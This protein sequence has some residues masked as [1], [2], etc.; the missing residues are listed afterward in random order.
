MNEMATTIPQHYSDALP[1]E[2]QL[3]FALSKLKQGSVNE[4]AIELM[5]LKGVSTEDGVGDLTVQ[6]EK[7]VEKLC[8]EGI[9]EVVK[10]RHH[11][12]RYQFA[13]AS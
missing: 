1:F 2:Q 3:L 4:I 6:T 5:E 8:E 10:D 9:L 7:E 12:R 11:Q 13:L